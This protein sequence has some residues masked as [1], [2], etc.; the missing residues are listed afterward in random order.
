M[1]YHF[2]GYYEGK[3]RRWNSNLDNGMSF[4]LDTYALVMLKHAST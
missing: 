4:L 2:I 3:E 1:P